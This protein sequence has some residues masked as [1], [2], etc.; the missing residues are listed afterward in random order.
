MAMDDGKRPPGPATAQ[1]AVSLT[2]ANPTVSLST[3]GGSSG[4]LHVN[5]NW[6][7]GSLRRGLFAKQGGGIDLDLGA[8]YELSD[9]TKGV[10]QAV[11]RCFGA[12]DRPPY[13]WLDGDDRSG[14]Y[15]GGENLYIE[16]SYA[17][18]IRRVLVFASIYEGAPR[19]DAAQ[20][21]VTITPAS[22]APIIMRLDEAAGTRRTCAVAQL[23]NEAG[24]LTI[25]REVRFIDGNQQELDAAYRWG[26]TWSPMRR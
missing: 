4:Q 3:R 26:M 10:V 12:A 15:V 5:L 17:A 11:G 23:I 1:A 20:A 9:G 18:H 6:Q 19:F 22:G 7:S 14:G 13:I 21:V 24:E 16:L 25:H 2:K 8:L